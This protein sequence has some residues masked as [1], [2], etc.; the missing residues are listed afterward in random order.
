MLYSYP[1]EAATDNWL[2]ECLVATIENVHVRVEANQK[3]P[4]WP[5]IVSEAHRD[6]LNAKD[7][8]KL[9]KLISNYNSELKKLD[10]QERQQVRDAVGEQNQLQ[11]LFRDESNCEELS[12]LPEGVRQPA[13][14]LCVYVFGLLTDFGVRKSQYEIVWAAIEDKVCPFCGIE[15][16]AATSAP[17]EDLDHYLPK[18]RYPFA[19]ANLAN[20]VPAGSDC[21]RKY[22]RDDNPL[23]KDGVRRRALNPY[24]DSTLSISLVNS[25]P[26]EGA[27]GLEFT[28]QIDFQPADVEAET[29]DDVYNLRERYERDILTPYWKRWIDAFAKF[30]IDKGETTDVELAAFVPRW[31]GILQVEG[32]SDRAFLKVAFFEMVAH[33]LDAGNAALLRLI[34]NTVDDLLA[35]NA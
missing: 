24:G 20:L 17:S 34:R 18:S 7:R 27:D 1:E 22:K 30:S 28:W 4:R 5:S 33:H 2:H 10:P 21:N 32:L 35:L 14:D 16:F 13:K 19:A 3:L 12:A 26:F 8:D 6:Q 23:F 25:V 15:G 31:R 9:K 11:Q 29:W